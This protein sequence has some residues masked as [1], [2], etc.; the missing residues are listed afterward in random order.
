M[1]IIRIKTT[2]VTKINV[3]MN[4]MGSQTEKRIKFKKII[5]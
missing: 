5:F 2:M 3:M 4:H 1:E